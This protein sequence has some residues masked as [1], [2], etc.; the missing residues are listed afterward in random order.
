MA[1]VAEKKALAE[2]ADEIRAAQKEADGKAKV[3]PIVD[4]FTDKDLKATRDIKEVMKDRVEILPGSL[5]LK[6]KPE[7]TIAENL[8][9]LDEVVH[10]EDHV[11][12]MIGDVLNYGELT[13]GRARYDDVLHRTGRA[14][15]TLYQYAQT[16]RLIPFSKRIMELPFTQHRQLNPLGE[17]PDKLDNALAQIKE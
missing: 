12:F 6:L 9:I 14:Q 5:G 1:S 13:Y 11:Q 7:T 4:K 17:F 3:V 2:G 8:Q 10:M 15:S 16:A